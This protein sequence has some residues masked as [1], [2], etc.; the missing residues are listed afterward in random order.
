MSESREGAK[1]WE[2]PKL[3]MDAASTSAIHVITVRSAMLSIT[4]NV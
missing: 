2:K 4:G 3:A 1:E